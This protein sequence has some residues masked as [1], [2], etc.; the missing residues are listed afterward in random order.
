MDDKKS[1][2]NSTKSQF[3]IKHALK[4]KNVKII[5]VFSYLKTLVATCLTLQT[6]D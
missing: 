1:D 2:Q 3:Y 5:Q 6:Q 4:H